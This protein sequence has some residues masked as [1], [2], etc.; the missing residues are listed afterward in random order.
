MSMRTLGILFFTL[1]TF[2]VSGQ[3]TPSLMENIPFNIGTQ[4]PSQYFEGGFNN[5]IFAPVDLDRDG[6]LDLVILEKSEGRLYG[7]ENGGSPNQVDYVRN[8][9]LISGFPLNEFTHFLHFEDVNCDGV[10]DAFTYTPFGGAGIGLYFGEWINNRLTFNLYINRLYDASP[11]PRQIYA[12][13]SKKPEFIDVSG[14]GDLDIILFGQ[15]D[16]TIEWYENQRVENGGACDTVTFL[17]KANCWGEI[18]EC[19][20]IT[21][22]ITLNYSSALCFGLWNPNQNQQERSSNSSKD[23]STPGTRHAGSTLTLLDTDH[24]GWYEA[25]VGDAG[26]D[27][28]IFLKN[29][30]A[31]TNPTKDRMVSQDT[32]FPQYDVPIDFP[33]F[34]AAY[35]LDVDNDDRKDLIVASYGTNAC[36]LGGTADTSY[37]R[38]NVFW[39]KNIGTPTQDSF[40][41]VSKNF[42]VENMVD[43]G[44][45]TKPAWIDYNYDGLTD[46]VLG[47]C[48]AYDTLRSVQRGLVLFEN[49]GT[50]QQPAFT[51][52]NENFGQFGNQQ[53]FGLSPAFGDLD[54]DGDYDAV[55]GENGGFLYVMENTA[56][57]NNPP[58]FVPMDTLTSSSYPTPHIVDIN[59]DSRPDLVV[60]GLQGRLQYWQN[61]GLETDPEFTA[62]NNFFGEVDGRNGDFFGFTEPWLGDL[63]GDGHLEALVGTHS[64]AVFHYDQLEQALPSLPWKLVDSNYVPYQ[65][66][67][68]TGIDLADINGDGYWDIAMGNDRGGIAL[69]T[70]SFPVGTA[71]TSTVTALN[72]YPNP[73]DNWLTVEWLTASDEPVTV[74]VWDVLGRLQYRSTG[75]LLRKQLRIPIESWSPGLYLIQWQQ[76]EVKQHTK[77]VVK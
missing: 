9:D 19:S 24:D 69:F 18:C 51:L 27:N 66:G 73:A 71:P 54:G 68:T 41:L 64:G 58:I 49:T 14:D 35:Y 74:Q 31:Q 75:T 5:P 63:D 13:Q 4:M 38:G 2:S 36:A 11:Q 33:V 43:V 34:P 50:A 47:R 12:D 21:N 77:V 62:S 65:M 48:F 46:L 57:V 15:F 30:S 53:W 67:R 23:T 76:G 52:R 42:L 45:L 28:L 8:D 26:F 10:P 56:G 25:L 60:G 59:D 20:L 6:D 70:T 44:H 7:Y 55:I 16:G 22:E 29:N 40:Q 72:A 32:L 3:N 61:T 1:L 17:I 37:N 39:Y